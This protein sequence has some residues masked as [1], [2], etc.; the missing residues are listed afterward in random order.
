MASSY[1]SSLLFAVVV[2]LS[3]GAPSTAIAE[4]G[5]E[6]RIAAIASLTGPAAEQGKNWLEGA[7]LAADE[8]RAQGQAVRLIVEDDAT[9]AL[10]AASAFRKVVQIDRAQGA[11][12]GTWD[13]TAEAIYPLARELRIPFVTPSNPVEVMNGGKPSPYVFTNG[14]GIKASRQAVIDL[15]RRER[16]R[17]MAIVVPKLPFGT[18]HADMFESVAASEEVT[19]VLREEFEFVGYHDILRSIAL[20]LSRTKPDLVAV[21]IDY[22]ALD[23]F[24]AEMEKYRFQPIIL[25]TQHLDQAIVLSGNPARYAKAYGIYPRVADASFMTKFRHHFGR[26]PKVYA[27]EGYDAL[28]FLALGIASSANFERPGYSYEGVTGVHTI[29][30]DRSDLTHESGVLL[31]P[32]AAGVLEAVSFR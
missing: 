20:K 23:I 26:L 14:L 15:I 30:A 4:P 10:K 9:N 12:G 5:P 28:K 32:N 3:C 31:H 2:M 13:F 19:V 8:L 16:P 6:I 22:A 27:A 1:A 11:I 29:A 21:V 7:E 17:S 18:L 24:V 25:T